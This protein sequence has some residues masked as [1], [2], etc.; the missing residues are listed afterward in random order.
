MRE[1]AKTSAEVGGPPRARQTAVKTAA[2][3]AREASLPSLGW[4][5][6]PAPLYFTCTPRSAR[7][8][9]CGTKEGRPHHFPQQARAKSAPPCARSPLSHRHGAGS[10]R[11]DE[12][13][14]ISRMSDQA[15]GKAMVEAEEV[16]TFLRAQEQDHVTGRTLVVVSQGESPDFVV[17]RPTGSY[18]GL[19][20]TSVYRDPPNDSVYRDDDWYAA[21]DMVC[22]ICVAVEAKAEKRQAPHWKY[23]L[24]TILVLQL[25]DV[26]LE[27]VASYLDDYPLDE[28]RHYGFVEL[29]V[30]D[31]TMLDVY[32]GDIDLY[33]ILP[34]KWRGFHRVPGYGSRKPYG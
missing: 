12:A 27:D 13:G 2:G 9:G 4:S 6:V 15:V 28:F 29:W 34:K 26:P 19:E 21:N 3:V 18:A 32:G 10:F 33:G 1:S 8:C 20:L 25:R 22:G 16:N 17:K 31:M 14:Y 23:R 5:R 7:P 24:H 11:R 30:A